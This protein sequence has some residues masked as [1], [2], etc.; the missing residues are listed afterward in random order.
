M[1]AL[2]EEADPEDIFDIL[3]PVGEGAY[4]SVYKALDK[5]D[6]SL[7]ALKIMP[8]E[9]ESGSL[10]KEVALMKRCSS[11]HIVNFRGSFIKDGNIWL[12]MEYCGAGSVI[13][14]MRATKKMFNE[15]EICV[16]MRETLRGL[17][18]LH[19]IKLIHRDIKSGNILLNRK[20][21]CKL[22]DFGVS[23]AFENTINAAKT[24]IG[25]PYWMAPEVFTE[26]KYN[27]KADIWSLGIT[28]IEMAI[29]KPPHCDKS[30][31]QVI[32]YIPRSDPP[33]LPEDRLEF[34]SDFRDFIRQ[35]CIKDPSERPSAKQLLGHQWIKSAKGIRIVQQLVS[36]AQPLVEAA[37]KKKKEEEE[38]EMREQERLEMMEYQ[39]GLDADGGNNDGMYDTAVYNDGT[40]LIYDDEGVNDKGPG[41][42]DGTMIRN[43]ADE[44]DRNDESYDSG[45]EY[46]TMLINNG[47]NEE[48]EEEQPE[49]DH[50][51]AI[52]SDEEEDM[53]DNGTMLIND[54]EETQTKKVFESMFKNNK[55]VDE[56]L[57]IPHDVSK[58]ELAKI[59]KRLKHVTEIDTKNLQNFYKEQIQIIEE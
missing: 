57:P 24:V 34:S 15:E 54:V 36:K 39:D 38:E 35:C 45:Q 5:R 32:F 3:V 21:Q 56:L 4:G 19:S 41:F 14:I 53:Y 58:G 42:D 51:N 22:A 27:T 17:M 11:P 49:E 25:T 2:S 1:E 18:Y 33:N 30:P 52:Y 40:S 6:S 26:G 43:E 50:K 7:V 46:G 59:F 8:L 10:E 12:A 37:R 48:Y 28:A 13:D 9:V 55:F 44:M 31:L 29:G 23:K 47:A 16:V 20:G